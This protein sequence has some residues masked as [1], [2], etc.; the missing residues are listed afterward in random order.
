MADREV[1]TI[2]NSGEITTI[3]LGGSGVGDVVQVKDDFDALQVQID[4]NK[5][6]DNAIS[7]NTEADFSTINIGGTNYNVLDDDSIYL[8]KKAITFTRG[9][10]ASG[11]YTGTVQIITSLSFQHSFTSVDAIFYGDSSNKF[12]RMFIRTMTIT[13]SATTSLFD[14]DPLTPTQ[15]GTWNWSD[16]VIDGIEMGSITGT[17]IHKNSNIINQKNRWD[18]AVAVLNFIY[19]NGV[20]II[21]EASVAFGGSHIKIRGTTAGTIEIN[22]INAVPSTGDTAF[23][24]T[25]LVTTAGLADVFHVTALGSGGV[26]GAGEDKTITAFADAGGGQVTV[27][28]VNHNIPTGNSV[29]ITGT[30]SYNGNFQ[31]TNVTTNTF[32]IT[33]TFVADDATGTINA[34]VVDQTDPLLVVTGA[35]GTGNLDSTTKA[36]IAFTGNSTETVIGSIGVAVKINATWVIN[37]DERFTTDTTGRATYVGLEN[38]SVTVHAV[39]FYRPAS[40]G[41][42]NLS[43]FIAINGTIVA[44]TR[45]RTAATGGAAGQSVSVSLENLVTGDFIEAFIAND[46]NITNIV[47]EDCKVVVSKA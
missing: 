9:F 24:F 38:I 28:S 5:N 45:G 26:Y 2:L 46:D 17:V 7:I 14:K 27:T 43:C 41:S 37:G 36:S 10:A 13:G 47:V 39:P 33:D 32:E 42:T 3:H 44:D 35:R 8:F 12:S 22:T 6:L 21:G 30:T 29:D 1:N 40:G 19:F 20:F 15:I 34:T 4:A 18:I 25:E 16:G 23:D 31:I 11:I